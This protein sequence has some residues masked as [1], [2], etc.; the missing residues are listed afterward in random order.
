[1]RIIA[2]MALWLILSAS[3]MAHDSGVMEQL[4]QDIVGKSYV[5][6]T[7]LA[8]NTC[9]FTGNLDFPT[10]RLVDTEIGEEGGIRYF[11]RADRFMNIRHCTGS[12]GRVEMTLATGNYIDSSLV[13]HMYF[14]GSRATVKSIDAKP[15]R[16]EIQ[17]SPDGAHS[18]DDAYAKVKLMLGKGYESRRLEQI[19]LVLANA[20]VL[21]RIETIRAETA[22]LDSVR[23]A[24]SELERELTTERTAEGRVDKASQLVNQYQG[25]VSAEER[26]NKV[27]FQPVSVDSPASRIAELKSIVLEAQGQIADAQ[28]RN[29]IDQYKASALLLKSSCG[30][31]NAPPPT[32]RSELNKALATLDTARQ[33][34]ERFERAQREMQKLMLEV[35]AGDTQFYA[36]CIT[37]SEVMSRTLNAQQQ[38]ILQ[39]EAEAADRRRQAQL[40]EERRAMELRNEENRKIVAASVARQQYAAAL[41]SRMSDEIAWCATGRENDILAGYIKASRLSDSVVAQLSGSSPLWREFY[42]KGFRYRGILDRDRAIKVAQI[43]ERGGFSLQASSMPENEHADLKGAVQSL[44]DSGSCRVGQ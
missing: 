2:N 10:S 14:R 27:A 19:E 32:D 15:D 12:A 9:L 38:A 22:R 11:L 43:S 31:L 1:M 37:N 28:I 25:L 39:T 34:I 23:S 29:T 41:T 33:K 13:T 42:T 35:P 3:M 44:A 20:L 8:G 30:L 36:S 6:A 40:A 5:L 17:L 18:G 21:P 7:T 16:I 26:L 4:R 24:I